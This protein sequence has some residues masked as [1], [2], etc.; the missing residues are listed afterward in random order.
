MKHL[1]H[2]DFLY[3]P[4]LEYIKNF[5]SN[6]KNIN[7]LEF[8]VMHGRST[9][10]FLEVCDNMDGTLTSIDINDHSDLFKNERWKFI[11][12]R[13]DNFELMDQIKNK[14]F[15]VIYIDSLH[16]PNHI[17]KILYFYY[18]FLKL[19]GRIFIDDINW[20][21]YVKN[22]F[23]DN[24]YSELINRKTFSKIIEIYYANLENIQLE[25]N[26]N[27]TGNANILKL[28]DK[29]LNEA[30]KIHNRLFGLRNIIRNI[31]LIKR[32]PKM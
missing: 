20:L 13:D 10:M 14:S 5:I 22:S 16:E 27:G 31:L 30:K 15:D 4:K 32:K 3:Y 26:F 1:N 19:N 23:K 28:K 11:K 8:G 29:K 18:D 9:K 17:K 2:V 7:I 25:F 12:S 21:P 24:E 6:I